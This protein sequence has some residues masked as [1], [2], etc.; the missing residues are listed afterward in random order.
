MDLDGPFSSS[1]TVCLPG[2]V[3]A[4]TP[5]HF[6]N[7]MGHIFGKHMGVGQ[8]TYEIT[9]C[10][11]YT[12][13]INIQLYQLYVKCCFGCR[14]GRVKPTSHSKSSWVH[15]QFWRGLV[16]DFPYPCGAPCGDPRAI[17]KRHSRYSY[18][19]NHRIV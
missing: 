14:T 7:G 15:S 9:I 19:Q 3:Y 2:R 10:V 17:K 12:G 6:A 13:V 1:R 18:P 16:R 11:G 4:P 5:L 8:V